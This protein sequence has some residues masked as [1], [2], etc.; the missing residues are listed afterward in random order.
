MNLEYHAPGPGAPIVRLAALSQIA[1]RAGCAI[2]DVYNLPAGADG[3]YVEY[4]SDM[5]PLTVADVASNNVIVDMLGEFFPGI[6]VVS[7]ENK[8]ESFAERRKYKYYFCVD[9]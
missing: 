1:E 3:S 2:L 7:E 4:K 9:A 6:H 5:S 8:L